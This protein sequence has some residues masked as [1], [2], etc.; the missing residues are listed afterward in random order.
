VTLF[1]DVAVVQI[2]SWLARTPHLRGRR[3]ASRMIREATMA[4]AVDTM[5]TK[6]TDKARR[7]TAYGDI[8]GVIAL[9]LLCDDAVDDV[10]HHVVRYLREALPAAPLRSTRWEGQDSLDAHA[11]DEPLVTRDWPAPVSEWPASKPCDWCRSWPAGRE[12]VVGAG[13]DR[14]QVQL[15]EDCAKRHSC[16]GFTSSKTAALT[17]GVERDLLKR[18]KAQHGRDITLPD[19]FPDLALLGKENDN[20]HLATVYADGNA[21]GKL[22][23][24]LRDLRRD[25][26]GTTFDLPSA[27]ENATWSAL[28]AAIEGMSADTDETMPVIAH[29]VGGDDVLVS[30]PAHEAWSF[31]RT[32]QTTFQDALA[33]ELA[34]AGLVELPVPTVSA[35]IVFHHKFSP[36][37]AAVDM[38]AELLAHAKKEHRGRQASLAWQDITHDGPTPLHQQQIERRAP[39]LEDLTNAWTDLDALAELAASARA[40]LAVLARQKD[41]ER[42]QAHAERLGLGTLVKRVLDGPIPLG[43]ALG[44]V[45]WWR[46]I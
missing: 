9:E 41:K 14:K 21:V 35:A 15:C 16:A 30:I 1:L 3:G 20:T 4:E 34:D 39:S 33:A 37:P 31:A 46:T 29:L 44:M 42:V 38:A 6:I 40:N 36:L 25:G 7:N 18:W 22:N 11:A 27:I 26:I 43:D 13:G 12:A 10:E 24:E 19:K 23:K 5:L 32:L 28:L 45:R 17:P 8:D 2:Q